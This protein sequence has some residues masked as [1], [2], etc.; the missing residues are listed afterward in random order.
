MVNLEK[1]RH[2]ERYEKVKKF[3]KREKW[4]FVALFIEN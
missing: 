1:K 2:E 3:I 4:E